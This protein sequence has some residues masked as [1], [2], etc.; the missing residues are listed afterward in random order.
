ME[1]RQ[2]GIARSA[3]PK[4]PRLLRDLF[5][6]AITVEFLIQKK[7]SRDGAAASKGYETAYILGLQQ[8]HL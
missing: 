7:T 6:K 1:K 5:V 4:K 2:S 8:G 3:C